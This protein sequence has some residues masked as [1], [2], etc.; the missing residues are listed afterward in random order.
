MP[1]P[2]NI[3]RGETVFGVQ[4]IERRAS[5]GKIIIQLLMLCDYKL[6]LSNSV[7]KTF[8]PSGVKDWAFK[9]LD[10]LKNPSYVN[11]D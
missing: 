1:N 7:L 11:S 8:A 10:F 3:D 6:H 5:D 9:L 2:E 4:K